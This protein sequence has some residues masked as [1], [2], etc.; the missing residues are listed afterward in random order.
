V[1]R[2]KDFSSSESRHS[3]VADADLR[4]RPATLAMIAIILVFYFTQL[5]SAWAI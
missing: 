2:S 1:R 5:P 4:L 3:R